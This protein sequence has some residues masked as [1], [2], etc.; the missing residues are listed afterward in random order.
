[1]HLLAV[2]ASLLCGMAVC[3]PPLHARGM[4]NI[5]AAVHRRCPEIHCTEAEWRD[6][7]DWALLD[8][9]PAFTVGEGPFVATFWQSLTAATPALSARSADEC[10]RRYGKLSQ[11]Q[12]PV[13]RQPPV[14]EDW[15][16]CDGGR[17]SGRV[18]GGT[19]YVWLTVALEGRLA[20][21]PREEPGYIEAVG[22]RVFELS[23]AGAAAGAPA[24]ASSPASET[25]GA[26]KGEPAL[27]ARLVAIA[28]EASVAAAAAILAGGIGFGIGTSVAPPPALPP[29]APTPPM[30]VFIAS[31]SSGGA[32]QGAPSSA[33][34]SLAAPS[35]ASL[36]LSEQRERAELRVD[37]DK[38]R[39]QML[40]QRLKEDEQRV[41]EYR[42][43]EAERGSNADAVRLV[44]PP[45]SS[46]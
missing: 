9:A 32:L 37:R 2:H 26:G 10:E 45:A 25:S 39:L 13:G 41:S 19:S 6:A 5:R 16:K 21:D 42:R 31:S 7:E 12:T 46:P 40:Q 29:A 4:R 17:Y 1:M 36:T 28:R 20:G 43:L 18:A 3:R 38:A 34:G 22:G 35:T 33:A 44:F 15:T 27:S 14:L 23:R 30:R 11:N 24:S 8:A